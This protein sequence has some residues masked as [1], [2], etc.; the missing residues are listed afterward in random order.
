MKS[1]VILFCFLYCAFQSFGQMNLVPNPSFEDY[2]QCPTAYDQ[3]DRATG[4]STYSESTDYFNSCSNLTSSGVGVPFNSWGQQ[5][6]K[7]GSGYTF[8]E[9]NDIQQ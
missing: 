9:T 7:G 2:M 1:I 3:I 4:W 6:A 5:W 8:F